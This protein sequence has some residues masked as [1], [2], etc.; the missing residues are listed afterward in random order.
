MRRLL[1][2]GA[3]GLIALSAMRLNAWAQVTEWAQP[4]E[5]RGR[6]GIS[7][8]PSLTLVGA[9]VDSAGSTVQLFVYNP[10]AEPVT[11]S[12]YHVKVVKQKFVVTDLSVN[13]ADFV[14]GWRPERIAS[15]ILFDKREGNVVTSAT[16]DSINI[17]PLRIKLDSPTPN[18]AYLPKVLKDVT[19]ESTT[20]YPCGPV[21]R[22]LT[23]VFTTPADETNLDNDM[24]LLFNRMH[25][26]TEENQNVLTALRTTTGTAVTRLDIDREWLWVVA[27]P[28]KLA[29]AVI[30]VP[31]SHDLIRYECSLVYDVP[32]IIVPAGAPPMVL[33]IP[34]AQFTEGD[35]SCLPSPGERVVFS[36]YNEVGALVLGGLKTAQ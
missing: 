28:L 22:A 2:T 18:A 24:K 26:H 3:F 31:H 36:A 29:P 21:L 1:I 23:K 8:S 33:S 13:T 15:N 17:K 9:N 27:D 35:N 10:L 34:L 12:Q 7:V 11:V 4:T 16:A 25:S 20:C 5:P 30:D 6:R 32:P 14:N 19:A